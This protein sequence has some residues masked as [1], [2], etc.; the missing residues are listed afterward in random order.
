MRKKHIGCLQD[1]LVCV[2]EREKKDGGKKKKRRVISCH[3][4]HLSKSVTINKHKSIFSR[5]YTVMVVLHLCFSPPLPFLFSLLLVPPF[6]RS[7]QRIVARA[8]SLCV[9]QLE[10]S[11]DGS[12]AVVGTPSS[13]CFIF[14]L[15]SLTPLVHERDLHG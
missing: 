12:L 11:A 9:S 2:Q 10:I 15:P 6:L 13:A 7:L 3:L 5:G 4:I 8:R 1:A 14:D